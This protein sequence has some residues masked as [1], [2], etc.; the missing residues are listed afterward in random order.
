MVIRGVEIP[1]VPVRKTDPKGG[2]PSFFQN[3]N[4]DPDGIKVTIYD[5]W[6]LQNQH[7]SG[8]SFDELFWEMGLEIIRQ[9]QP[10][11]RYDRK[12][13]FTFDRLIIVKSAT[14]DGSRVDMGSSIT[15]EGKTFKLAYP[16][17]QKFCGL[18]QI[19]HGK[20]CPRR[21]RFEEMQEKRKA[22]TIKSKMYATSTLRHA[23]QLALT[24]NVA[25]MSG[26]SIAQICNFLPYDDKFEEV[27]I[28]GGTNEVHSSDPI[29]E[30]VYTVEQTAKKIEEVAKNY[31]KVSLVLPPIPKDIPELTAK[32]EYLNEKLSAINS[33]KVL[34]L[35]PVELDNTNH[36]TVEGTKNIIQQIDTAVGNVIM[37]DC[38][39]D[40][41]V[42][43]KYNKVQALYKV[44]CRG[45]ERKEYTSTLCEQCKDTA[46]GADIQPLVSRIEKLIEEMYPNVDEVEM[47]TIYNKRQAHGGHYGPSTKRSR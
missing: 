36:P 33:V 19:K 27:I 23:N 10:K 32:A 1:L 34:S 21:K 37:E 13:M 43:L 12:D 14:N 11:R 7:I 25:C 35:S 6:Q 29:H 15:V 44:G 30:F 40:I 24:S 9:T 26:G 16:G 31:E 28:S 8:E 47:K 46:K 2:G 4:F 18:C 41:V 5:A 22:M 45:C 20:E 38:Q 39:D 42:P 17:I 3:P